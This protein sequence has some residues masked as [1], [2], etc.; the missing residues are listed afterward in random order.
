MPATN[1]Y[2][3]IRLPAG[4][5]ALGLRNPWRFSFDRLTADMYI[6]D[7]GRTSTEVDFQPAASPGQENSGWNIIEENRAVASTYNNRLILPIATYDHSWAAQSRGRGP[8][9]AQQRPRRH[10]SH[11]DFCSRIGP[12]RVAGHVVAACS[13]RSHPDRS[14]G[15]DEGEVYAAD[16]DN[17]HIYRVVPVT[18]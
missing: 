18:Q 14:F 8:R 5:W 9:G 16:Y 13:V 12:A 6:S 10:L 7:V 1:P 2:V 11:A 17:G 15:E 4:I 3:R